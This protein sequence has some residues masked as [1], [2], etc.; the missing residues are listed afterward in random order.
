MYAAEMVSIILSTLLS[1]CK[2]AV[3][4][5]RDGE[6]FL[7]FSSHRFLVLVINIINCVSSA[8]HAVSLSIRAQWWIAA[9]KFTVDRAIR[10]NLDQG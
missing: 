6:S 5:E 2:L 1:F 3:T 4:C 7:F 10:K 9:R 8:A